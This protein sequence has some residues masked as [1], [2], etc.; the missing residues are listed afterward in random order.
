M[1]QVTDVDYRIQLVSQPTKRRVIHYDTIKPFEGTGRFDDEETVAQY[2]SDVPDA[3]NIYKNVDPLDKHLED[4]AD[5][6]MPRADYQ[7]DLPSSSHSQNGYLSNS[8]LDEERSSPRRRRKLRPRNKIRKP[9]R[10]LD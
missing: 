2:D 4:M 6:F 7:T 9:A 5:L 10:F 3:P 1:E 8:S